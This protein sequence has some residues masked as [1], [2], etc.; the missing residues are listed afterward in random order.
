MK[1]PAV[2]VGS[3]EPGSREWNAVRSMGLGGSEIA[4]VMNLSPYES[5][6]SLWNRKRGLIA[7]APSNDAMRRGDRLEPVVAEWFAEQHPEYRVRRTGMW[8][9]RQ[10]PWQLATP[11]RILTG[12]GG[13]AL[14]KAKTAAD[15]FEWGRRGTDEVPGYVRCQVLWQLDALGLDRAHVAVLTTNLEF[16]EYAVEWNLTE[17][18]ALRAAAREFLDSVDRGVRPEIDEHAATYRAVRELHPEIDDTEVEIE[19]GL[20]EQYRAA[21]ADHKRAEAVKLQATSE[22]L[23]ALGRHRRALVNG[24]SVAIRVPGRNGAAPSLRPSPV[25]AGAA[26]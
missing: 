6:F 16:R 22:V 2:R 8:A 18:E 20:A 5:A 24:E 17:A 25:R 3:F 14:L 4:A 15:L 21:V 10:R 11:D 23:D 7:P 1:A 12:L 13:R 19:P 9:N 26:A